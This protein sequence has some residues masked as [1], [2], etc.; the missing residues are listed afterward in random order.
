MVTRMNVL[1]V[2]DEVLTRMVLAEELADA[3][4]DVIEAASAETA[5]SAAAVAGEAGTPPAVLVTD[6][7]LGE[8]MDGLALVAEVRRRWPDMGIIVMTG[9]PANRERR[10][11]NPREVWLLKPFG[12]PRLT[13]AVH[14]LMG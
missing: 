13:A 5:L 8:G 1:L 6:V 11:A 9:M 3:G 12:P 4:H 10:D 7:N 2:E 14:E